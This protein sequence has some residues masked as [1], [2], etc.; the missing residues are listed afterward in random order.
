MKNT[1]KNGYTTQLDTTL[2]KQLTMQLKR[3]TNFNHTTVEPQ[4]NPV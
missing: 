1:G 2:R 3:G 4:F